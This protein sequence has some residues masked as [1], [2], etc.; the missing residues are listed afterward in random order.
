M[1]PSPPEHPFKMFATV[2]LGDLHG[3]AKRVNGG[4]GVGK[5]R[6]MRSRT[7][8]VFPFVP[9][10]GL[11]EPQVFLSCFTLAVPSALTSPMSSHTLWIKLN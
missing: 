4:T 3:N 6:G 5:H 10:S 8:P 11:A 7:L 9:S 1:E 2:F